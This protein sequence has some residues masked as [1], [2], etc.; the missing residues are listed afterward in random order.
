MWISTN[1]KMLKEME[2]PDHLTCHLRKLYVVQEA[3]VRTLYGKIYWLKIG[4]GVQQGFTLS[5]CLFNFYSEYTMQ[6]AG[7]DETQAGIKTARRNTNN[8]RYADN[9]TLMAEIEEELKSLL[10][11]GKQE[12]EKAGVKFNIQK[13]KI[14]ASSSI[15]S[16]KIEGG[17]WKHCQ[18][19]QNHHRW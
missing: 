4:K 1:W 10:R 18:W 3:T 5:P 7:L 11:R 12:S 16:W 13:I 14:M 8:L 9:T 6:N 15:I 17:K 19:F 2:I